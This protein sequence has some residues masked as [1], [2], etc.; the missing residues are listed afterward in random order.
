MS[1]TFLAPQFL[2]ALLALPV[3]LLLHFIRARKKRQ[4]VSALFLWKEA[5]KLAEQRRR[6]SPT[7]LLFLQL[8]FAGLAAL[9]LSQPR[10]TVA[11]PPERVVIVDASASMMARDSDGVRLEKAKREA[12]SLIQ[13]AGRVAVVRAGL[14]A[15]VV[16]SLSSDRAEAERALASLEAGDREADLE[17]AVSLALSLAPEAEIHVFTDGTPPAGQ[18]FVSHPV[19]GDALNVGIITFDV[20]LQQA[21]V[22]VASNHPRPQELGLELL[23]DGSLVAQSTLLVP[24]EGRANI[25][26]PLQVAEGV[27][28]A[29]IVA[30][31]WDAL[32]LDD[33]AFAGRRNLRLAVATEDEAILRALEAIPNLSY[34]QLNAAGLNAPGFDARLVVGTLP[35]PL[36]EGKLLLFAPPAAAPE[37]QV[38]RDWDRADPLLRF[39]SLEDTVVGLEPDSL[40]FG[41]SGEGWRVLASTGDL[42][43]VL[44]HYQDAERSVVAFNVHPEQTDMVNRTAFPLLMANIMD[45]FREEE[46]LPLGT[47]LPPGSVLVRGEREEPRSQALSP[48]IYRVEDRL[49]AISLLSAAETRLPAPPPSPT[50]QDSGAAASEQLWAAALWLVL[51]AALALLAEWL[52]FTGG[53]ARGFGLRSRR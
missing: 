27:F 28:E 2:W 40:P 48:G 4:P 18:R 46:T 43:P 47:Q 30:P 15:T 38:I 9:A 45:S 24:A 31:E 1:L 32:T 39:V 23:Q 14:D 53:Y 29:R 22:S 25:S 10:L 50:S 19:G 52:L 36:P 8:L 44:L 21:F 5:K 49:V 13:G 17:R 34:Q 6:F 3:I 41:V 16:Q 33:S 42:R 37:Y 26:F 20:G 12:A 35:D 11:G 7:W 51:L